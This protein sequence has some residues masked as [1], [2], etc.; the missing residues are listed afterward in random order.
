MRRCQDLPGDVGVLG[1]LAL[2]ERERAQQ[3]SAR[4]GGKIETTRFDVPG[5]RGACRID[6]VP[7][8]E[9]ARLHLLHTRTQEHQ[10]IVEVAR[11]GEAHGDVAEFVAEL[12]HGPWPFVRI[13]T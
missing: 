9:P 1:I 5:Q 7:L 11:L 13:E 10:K 2:V 4:S 3:G 8:V 12:G 6:V